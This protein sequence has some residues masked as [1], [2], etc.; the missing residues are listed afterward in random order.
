MTA[1]NTTG[2]RVTAKAKLAAMQAENDELKL[3]IEKLKAVNLVQ[4][5]RLVDQNLLKS[6]IDE[7]KKLS[8]ERDD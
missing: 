2:K 4:L 5:R 6:R 3:T 7:L 1:S 8:E